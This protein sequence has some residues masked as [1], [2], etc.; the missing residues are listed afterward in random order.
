MLL[1]DLKASLSN[2]SEKIMYKTSSNAH[3]TL[4]NTLLK[5]I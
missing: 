3:T 1:G 4:Q 2:S 5:K